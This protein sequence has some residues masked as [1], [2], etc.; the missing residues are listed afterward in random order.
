MALARFI[1]VGGVSTHYLEAGSGP[2]LVLLHG[3]AFGIDAAF[4]WQ[5]QVD[6]LSKRF[7]VIA[8]DQIGFGKTDMPGDGRYLNRLERAPHVMAFL[9][10][11][12]IASAILA[13]HS[14]GAF[15]ATW[16]ALNAPELVSKLI[17]LTSGGTAPPFGDARDQSWME[18]S[19][20]LYDY[21]RTTP[22]ADEL[23]AGLKKLLKRWDASIEA[24]A[25]ASHADA[26]AKGQFEMLANAP[27]AEKDYRLYTKLQEAHIH[28][29]LKDLA[30]PTL[31]LW[32]RNDATVPVG[33]GLLLLDMIRQAD[34]HVLADTAHS[35]MIDR[36]DAV[37]GIITQWA[38]A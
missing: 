19:D 25:R 8:L 9:R 13:G 26:A 15:T 17:L 3:A 35:L 21:R 32:S 1:D 30:C 14:E 10:R 18:A 36:P 20:A 33:R 27:A 34:F 12:G 7:R 11:L 23:I 16:I 6:A 28:P 29:R 38:E 24:Q 4:T 22:T 31:L 37:N 2:P 5:C